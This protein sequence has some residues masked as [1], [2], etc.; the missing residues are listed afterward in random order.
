MVS[1]CG[2]KRMKMRSFLA[3]TLAYSFTSVFITD[4]GLSFCTSSESL[5]GLGIVVMTDCNIS[6]GSEPE[7]A[8]WL[9]RLDRFGDTMDA[10]CL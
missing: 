2:S 1:V 5:P 8:A 6:L 9:K 3:I 7:D 10:N 4:M